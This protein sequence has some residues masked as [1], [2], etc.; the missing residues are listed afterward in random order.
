MIATARGG[1]HSVAKFDDPDGTH[2]GTTLEPAQY[3][4]IGSG[5][6]FGARKGLADADF[7]MPAEHAPGVADAMDSVSAK[8]KTIAAP[9][10]PH[11][12]DDGPTALVSETAGPYH[13]TAF[14][15]GNGDMSDEGGRF[16]QVTD[17]TDFH[18]SLGG[19]SGDQLTVDAGDVAG[20]TGAIRKVAT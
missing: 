18:D 14:H 1:G 9:T 7:A 4:A 13:V 5:S 10:D 11:A 20:V 2:L 15:D 3:V 17:R 12:F 19:G 8:S 16:V 6:Q